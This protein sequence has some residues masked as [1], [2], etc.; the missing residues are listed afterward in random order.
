[1]PHDSWSESRN[2]HCPDKTPL[3]A[4]SRTL[5]SPDG[6][7]LARFTESPR[8]EA[9]RVASHQATKASVTLLRADF[10]AARKRAIC[11]RVSPATDAGVR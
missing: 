4:R 6:L 1:V 2:R 10:R 7:R 9:T 8:R 11:R 3:I 5:L